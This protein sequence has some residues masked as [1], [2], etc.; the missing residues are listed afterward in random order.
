MNKELIAKLDEIMPGV[1]TWNEYEEKMMEKEVEMSL[2]NNEIERL[3]KQSPLLEVFYVLVGAFLMYGTTVSNV[4]PFLPG[5]RKAIAANTGVW[6]PILYFGWMAIVILMRLQNRKEDKEQLAEE[7]I[8]YEQLEKETERLEEERNQA[9]APFLNRLYELV[10]TKYAVPWV[11]QMLYEYLENGRADDM[12]EAVNLFEEEIRREREEKE[13]YARVQAEL[14]QKEK[15]L[16]E[17][18]DR[19]GVAERSVQ[20]F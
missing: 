10:P 19:L 5:V 13:F 1:D 3:K 15:E 11:I 8:K 18:R 9:I 16:E 7:Q 6:L 17:L 12:K 20:Y 4:L 14:E 2:C